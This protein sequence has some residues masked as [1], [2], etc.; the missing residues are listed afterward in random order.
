[1]A[2]EVRIFPKKHRPDF[3]SIEPIELLTLADALRISLRIMWM[4]LGN[5]SYNFYI[6]T[7][8][9]AAGICPFY[10]WHIEILPKVAVWAGFEIATGIEISSVDPERAAAYL[11][12]F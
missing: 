10:H 1:M 9:C 6:H 7:A 3:D 4:A 5:P 2:Y 12:R 8:P 11:R